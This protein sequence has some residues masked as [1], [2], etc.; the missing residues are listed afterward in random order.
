[1]TFE[2]EHSRRSSFLYISF[3]S[4]CVYGNFLHFHNT[5]LISVKIIF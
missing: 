3:V 4:S 1:M 2:F 5:N